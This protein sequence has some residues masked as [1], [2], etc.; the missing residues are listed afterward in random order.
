MYNTSTTTF[1][2]RQASLDS[3]TRNLCTCVS[4][5]TTRSSRCIQAHHSQSIAG[6]K[7]LSGKQ[8]IRKTSCSACTGRPGP[9]AGMKGRWP[10]RPSSMPFARSRKSCK[11]RP[12]TKRRRPR[13]YVHWFPSLPSLVPYSV[14]FK[15]LYLGG[16]EGGGTVVPRA[17]KEGRT[18]PPSQI[19]QRFHLVTGRK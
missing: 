19:H 4:L 5:T 1:R 9:P 13:G 10:P 8:E 14:L 2:H 11:R 15:V 3:Q 17:T 12:S 16:G 6:E 7:N 18:H